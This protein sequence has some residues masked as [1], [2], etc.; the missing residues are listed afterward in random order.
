[1]NEMPASAPKA[2]ASEVSSISSSDAKPILTSTLSH[3]STENSVYWLLDG[4]D[5][6]PRQVHAQHNLAVLRRA[7]LS[8]FYPARKAPRSA[9][10]PDVNEPVGKLTISRKFSPNRMFMPCQ[11]CLNLFSVQG[12]LLNTRQTSRKGLSRNKSRAAPHHRLFRH[13]QTS[14]Q[15]TLHQCLRSPTTA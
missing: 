4:D 13:I 12:I 5:S 1:M 2:F 3:R 14:S 7:L 10:L 15:R 6:R 9:F 11:R 8:I